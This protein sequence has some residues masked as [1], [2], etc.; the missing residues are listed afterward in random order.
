MSPF[1]TSLLPH[2]RGNANER[3]RQV[4]SRAGLTV[5]LSWALDLI[6]RRD[7]IPLWLSASLSVQLLE[8]VAV[9]PFARGRFPTRYL[10]AQIILM[11]V[12]MVAMASVHAGGVLIFW[13]SGQ[14]PLMALALMVLVGGILNNVAS[15]VDSRPLFYLGAIPYGLSLLAMPVLAWGQAREQVS[16]L[17]LTVGFFILAVHT[18]WGRMHADRRALVAARVEADR[19]RIETEEA[20]SDRTAMAAIVSHELRTPLSAILAGAHLI[21][22]GTAPAQTRATA[23]LIVDAGQ[24]MT[25]LLTDMLDQA[26]IEARAMNLEERDFDLLG[27]VLDAGRFWSANARAKGLTLVEPPTD[28]AA[29]WVRGDPFRLRQILNNLLSNAMKFTDEGAIALRVAVAPLGE[30]RVTVEIEVQDNGPGIAEDAMN[31]LFTPYAQASQETART[32]GG[33]GLGLAVSRQLARLMGG[34]LDARPGAPRGAV[35]RLRLE[36]PLGEAQD[37]ARASQPAAAAPNLAALNVL[38]VDDHEVNRRS[39]ALVLEPLGVSLTTAPDGLEALKALEAKAFDVVLMDVNMPG[40]DGREATRRLRAGKGLNHDTPVIG[41]SA[42]VA[43]HEVEACHAA[44]MTDW[45]A[46]PLDIR[47]LYAALDRAQSRVEHRAETRAE[48]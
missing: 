8:F 37:A 18:I 42:G 24:L 40:L 26:K 48:A 14:P 22:A 16:I 5:L 46:K 2:L 13:Q 19:R 31:R 25:G 45:I 6:G 17:A 44:G 9:R 29:V 34:E 47:A 3:Y 33:T 7:L 30:D 15:G 21:R 36:M 27:A 23:E 38:A 20:L 12:A 10:S 1:L 43:D 39:L 41:F 11:L 32:Y 28:Q 35:F 4:Y